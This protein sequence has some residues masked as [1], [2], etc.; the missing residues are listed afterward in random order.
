MN[1]N[2]KQLIFTALD[3]VM[4][5]QREKLYP[6][7]ALYIDGQVDMAS[8]FLQ[9]AGYYRQFLKWRDKRYGK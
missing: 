5:E 7:L 4:R 2:E 1:S 6:N 8:R 3:V 9:A